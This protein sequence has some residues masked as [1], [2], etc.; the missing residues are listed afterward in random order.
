MALS[1]PY[2]EQQKIKKKRKVDQTPN[3]TKLFHKSCDATN[4]QIFQSLRIMEA[5]SS[6]SILI[7]MVEPS[8]L[9]KVNGLMGYRMEYAMLKL[10]TLHEVFLHSIMERWMAVLGG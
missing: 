7:I 3:Q 5:F 10:K 8:F 4:Y 9:L 1:I 2:L 6:R